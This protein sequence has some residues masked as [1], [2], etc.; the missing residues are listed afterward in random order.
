MYISFTKQQEEVLDKLKKQEIRDIKD[1]NC[2]GS[3]TVAME[4]T[5]IY[6]TTIHA[7]LQRLKLRSFQLP[8]RSDSGRGR[9]TGSTGN[10]ATVHAGIGNS[11]F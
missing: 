2:C 5:S 3:D 4:S 8:R 11:Q 7:C 9:G 1:L 10:D 6:R